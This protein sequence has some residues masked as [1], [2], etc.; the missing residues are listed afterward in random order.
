[1]AFYERETKELPQSCSEGRSRITDCATEVFNSHR[2]VILGSKVCKPTLAAVADAE[3]RLR[4]LGLQPVVIW[5]QD[6]S[7]GLA[8][9]EL[10]KKFLTFSMSNFYLLWW[11]NPNTGRIT[12]TRRMNELQALEG[13]SLPQAFWRQED[14]SDNKKFMSWAFGRDQI[15]EMVSALIRNSSPVLSQ[16]QIN[17]FTPPPPPPS[18]TMGNR[19]TTASTS[20]TATPQ[21]AR[22]VDRLLKQFPNLVFGYARCPYFRKAVE[23]LQA[24]NRSDYIHVPMDTASD[25][26][27]QAVANRVGAAQWSSPLVFLYFKP[28]G[29][30]TQTIAWLKTH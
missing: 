24:S 6:N 11:K 22:D 5:Y 30:S 10:V 25:D 9:G 4:P 27:K 1:M 7:G 19:M 15:G 20:P 13:L 3:R 17:V 29:D 26:V 12:S 28:I 18:I 16:P 8:N 21:S 23:A 2:F 14:P